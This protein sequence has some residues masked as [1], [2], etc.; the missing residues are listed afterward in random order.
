MIAYCLDV[1]A[2][3]LWHK[4]QKV[5]E[6]ADQIADEGYVHLGG[7]PHPQQMGP[8]CTQPHALVNCEVVVVPS[9][10]VIE[11]LHG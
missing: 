1:D 11:L 6:S 3:E 2:Q 8:I 9:H 10:A 7:Q 5:G 4:A